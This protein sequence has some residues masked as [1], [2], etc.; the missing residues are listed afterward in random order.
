M[1]AYLD[2]PG[3]DRLPRLFCFH[4]AGGGASLFRQWQRALGPYVSVWPVLLPGREH[5]MREPRF[6]SLDALIADV[7]LH[8][9]PYL[10]APHLFFGHSMGALI[11]Y[12]LACHRRS[13][14]ETE[15]RALLL[16]AY[17]APDLPTPFPVTD[18]ADDDQLLQLLEG[19]GGIPGDLPPEWRA[20]LLAVFRDD[21][22]VCA[23]GAYL[24]E[25]PLACPIHLFGAD[26]DPIVGADDL[27][28]WDRCTTGQADVRILRGD[29][30]YLRDTPEPLFEELRPLL[31]GYA[32]TLAH[33]TV[34]PC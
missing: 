29:H 8:V 6:A 31:R 22:R 15:P 28:G 10:D 26:A 9:G 33:R 16:S 1:T 13:R 2:P 12:R 27:Q 3:G 21:M 18:D 25:Q 14:G 17:S 11:A 34:A 5:R 32:A 20:E 19:I 30:F 24:D 7:D 23:S 4:H